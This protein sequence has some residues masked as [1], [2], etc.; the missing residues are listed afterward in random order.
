M[1]AQRTAGRDAGLRPFRRRGPCRARIRPAEPRDAA[2]I[3]EM[4][5]ALA[6][7]TTGVPGQM[8]AETVRRELIGDRR[9]GCLVAEQAGEPVG[10]ALWSPA[11]ETAYAARGI[12]VSDLYVR[13]GLRRGGVGLALMRG[14]ARVCRS[15]GGRFLWWAVSPD[16]EAAQRFYDSLGA[17]S[18]PV[19]ARAVVDAH[20]LALAE[21]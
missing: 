1:T 13:P 7:L 5:N 18:D 9:L 11:Y 15:E 2:A 3:A 12:Y 14:V 16:N 4:A 19:D 20:F 17:I 6:M 10:Y 21:E 8:T